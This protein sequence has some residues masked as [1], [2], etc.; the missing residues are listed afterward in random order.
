MGLSL[1]C[2]WLTLAIFAALAAF[3]YSVHLP[4]GA[5]RHRPCIHGSQQSTLLAQFDVLD[6][7]D[8]VSFL[9]GQWRGELV[10]SGHALD[11]LLDVAGWYGKRFHSAEHVEPLLWRGPPWAPDAHHQI[12]FPLLPS[13]PIFNFVLRKC[14]DVLGESATPMLLALATLFHE[15][16]SQARLRHVACRGKV[17]V[18]MIYDVKPVIDHFRIESND[19][20][21]GL[22]DEKGDECAGEM[23][24]LFFRLRRD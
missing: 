22:M 17:G 10:S 20:M 7:V 11:G 1:E 16:R 24:H 3:F 23:Q 15:S 19:S 9:L 12:A 2:S 13:H 4:A 6:P 8:D 5:T 14:R 18:A 21:L